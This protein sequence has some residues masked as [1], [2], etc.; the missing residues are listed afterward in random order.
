MMDLTG[1]EWD[2][3]GRLVAAVGL[4][5]MLAYLLPGVMALSPAWTHR[6]RILAVGLLA[7]GLILAFVA[8]AAWFMR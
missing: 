4:A 8:T 3:I 2:G 7:V 5:A 6:M 1:S